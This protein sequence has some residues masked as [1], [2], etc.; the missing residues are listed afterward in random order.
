MVHA[1]S[2]NV[3]AVGY[4]W[5]DGELRVA[6]RNTAGYYVYTGVPAEV[7]AELLEAQSKGRFLHKHVIGR[8][9]YRHEGK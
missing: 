9:N 2:T 7:H 6:Y 5:D 4:D 8:Y 3:R 1:A